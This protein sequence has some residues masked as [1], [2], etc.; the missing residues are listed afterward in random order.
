MTRT[1]NQPECPVARTL[2]LLGDRWTLLIVR[3]LLRGHTRFGD[4]QASLPGLPSN[5]LSERLKLLEADGIVTRRFYSDHPPR[6]EYRLT[7]KGRD[8]REVMRALVLWGARHVLDAP[9]PQ[10]VHRACGHEVSLRWTCDHC[11]DADVGKDVIRP[12]RLRSAEAPPV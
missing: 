6:A 9:E 5:V 2:D 12:E 7:S 1:Y 8:L 4:L 10:L 3:D 11:R